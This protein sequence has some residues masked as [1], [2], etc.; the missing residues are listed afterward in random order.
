MRP[1]IG[2]CIL[3]GLFLSGCEEDPEIQ[4]RYFQSLPVL[5]C[6][7]N[8]NETEHVI[9]V[10]RMY[11]G[12]AAA[13]VSGKNADSLY[14]KNPDIKVHLAG[15]EQGRAI[16]PEPVW[17]TDKEPGFFHSPDYLV[18]KFSLPL[19][20]DKR[21][22][23]RSMNVSV[24]VPGLPAAAAT[25]ILQTPP[26]IWSPNI[27]QQTYYIVPDSPIRIQWSG[28]DWNEV[29]MYFEI[30]GQYPGGITTDTI[31]I[32]RVN[33]NF[34]NEKYYEVRFT[35][36]LL[37]ELIVKQFKPD[38]DL[39]RRYFGNVR[40]EVHTGNRDFS[41]YM[42][43]YYG[44][45]DFSDVSFSNVINGRGILASRSTTIRDSMR[46]DYWSRQNLSLDPRM[47][48]LGFLER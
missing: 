3:G 17:I 29:D 28:S 21:V 24:E 37:V 39:V 47:Q 4:T 5:F 38:K 26:V 40:T 6:M 9:R 20:S 36:E 25:T 8:V 35:F 34:I 15:F 11:S 19:V 23:Y 31:H 46:L 48:A 45:N 14:F 22:L 33:D 16:I 43:W 2:L 42:H 1:I 44:I 13:D 32:Q 18:Y 41:Q 12:N 10:E 30:I 27:S 7:I